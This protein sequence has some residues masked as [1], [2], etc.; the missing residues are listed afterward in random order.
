[1]IGRQITAILV[2]ATLSVAAAG[3]CVSGEKDPVASRTRRLV[4]SNGQGI[5][6]AEITVF[7]AS[8]KVLYRTRSDS[9]G[10]FSIPLLKNN[11]DR[12]TNDKNFRIEIEG[13][14]YIR[15]H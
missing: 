12:W 15:Y 3:Q 13:Q 9:H 8:R 5:P 2:A 6:N 11:R 14:G 10:K 7:D 4:N 1:M